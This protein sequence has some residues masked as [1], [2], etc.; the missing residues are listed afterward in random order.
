MTIYQTQQI[1][2]KSLSSTTQ[3]KKI[4]FTGTG[5]KVIITN[6]RNVGV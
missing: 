2:R 6:Q 1:V 3:T 4:I 5:S